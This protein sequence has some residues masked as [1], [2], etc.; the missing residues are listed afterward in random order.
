MVL[1]SRYSLCQ[2]Q[3]KF[4]PPLPAQDLFNVQLIPVVDMCLVHVS[5]VRCHENSAA[6][7]LSPGRRPSFTIGRQRLNVKDVEGRTANLALLE[8]L[9]QV[10]LDG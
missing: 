5:R 1:T 9:H 3:A 4:F 7:A 10:S 6:P 2:A 8:R